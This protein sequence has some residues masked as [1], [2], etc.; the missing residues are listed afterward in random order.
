LLGADQERNTAAEICK[1]LDPGV[2]ED[3]MHRVV[4]EEIRDMDRLTPAAC[5]NFCQPAWANRGFPIRFEKAARAV[6]SEPRKK[7]DHLFES[8]LQLLRLQQRRRTPA[9]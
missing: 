2:F 9:A 4:F 5:G 1:L 3:P 7:I 8:A 6:R